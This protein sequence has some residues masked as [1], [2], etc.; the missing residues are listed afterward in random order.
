MK[1]S[2]ILKKLRKFHKWPGIVICLFV[3][4][5]ALSGIV[6]NHRTLVS[7][8]S[9]S[10]KLLPSN[11]RYKNWNLAAIR[12]SVDNEFG[13]YIFG[14]VGIWKTTGKFENF[15]DFNNG[16]PKG[17]DNRKVNALVSFQPNVL[18]AGTQ[19]GLYKSPS[20]TSSWEKLELPTKNPR[21]A[22]LTMKEDTLIVLTRN[23]LLKTVD[24]LNFEKIQLP[25]PTNYKKK[26]GLFKTLWELHSGELFGSIGKILVDLL[27]LVVILLSVTGLLHF[28]FP[29]AIRKKKSKQKPFS[30]FVFYKRKNRRWHNVTGY[31]FVLFLIIN[32]ISGM[33]LRP[34]LLIAIANKQVGVIPFTHLDSPNPWQDKLRSVKWNSNDQQYIFSTSDGFYYGNENLKNHLKLFNNQPP[35]SVMGC[36]VLEELSPN[37]YLVGSFSGLYVWDIQNSFSYDLFSGKAYEKPSG[38]SKP[39][40]DH[41]VTGWI[42]P[43]TNGPI[44][45][46]YNKG[47]VPLNP[48]ESFSPMTDEMVKKSPMSL[49]NFSLELH[50]GR[51]FEHL[52]GPFY[53]L[54]VPMAGICLLIVLISGFFIWWL[55][56]RKK[57]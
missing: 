8:I 32:T 39:I 54:Y 12:G 30:A 28:I 14:N 46:D 5:F 11:Y 7:S 4:L 2:I 13:T 36:N 35:V 40:A 56:Y 26:V 51:I 21:I 31:V 53:I 43:K 10:R 50:T 18:V 41:M 45:F 25:P 27:G 17:I 1:S 52:L 38:M 33:H 24:L 19:S 15:D 34:P 48:Q 44:Y 55:G 20:E 9:V 3:I 22:D 23:Y 37:K 6:M 42:L 57:K 47:A 29:M 16:F 49:W